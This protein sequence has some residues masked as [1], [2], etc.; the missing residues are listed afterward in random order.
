MA[1]KEITSIDEFLP[2]A[3]ER[4]KGDVYKYIR[5]PYYLFGKVHRYTTISSSDVELSENLNYQ[6][7]LAFCFF[8][9]RYKRSSYLWFTNLS[10][11]FRRTGIKQTKWKSLR[12]FSFI[13]WQIW[14]VQSFLEGI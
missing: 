11:Y 5:V 8:F 13:C 2:S 9:L 4:F 6:T 10:G 7:P 12:N 3:T 1:Y 14:T